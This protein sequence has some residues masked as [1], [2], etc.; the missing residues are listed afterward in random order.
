MIPSL[1]HN[2]ASFKVPVPALKQALIACHP[3]SSSHERLSE[4]ALRHGGGVLLVQA[5]ELRLSLL[6]MIHAIDPDSVP[7]PRAIP[8]EVLA[9]ILAA[10]EIT[11]VNGTFSFDGDA[12]A[13]QLRRASDAGHTV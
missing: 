7:R 11:V 12:L 4:I 5:L 6:G 8:A 10:I 9:S 2:I 13:A 1:A 3:D